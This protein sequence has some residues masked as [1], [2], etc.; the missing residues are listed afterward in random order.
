MSYLGFNQT[1]KVVALNFSTIYNWSVDLIKATIISARIFAINTNFL[2]YRSQISYF[3]HIKWTRIMAPNPLLSHRHD[4]II[5]VS[6]TFRAFLC[7]NFLSV[8]SFTHI[9]NQISTEKIANF[10]RFLLVCR[11]QFSRF[12]VEGVQKL[13]KKSKRLYLGNPRLFFLP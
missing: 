13:R 8:V 2:E 11:P 3:A 6:S 5:Y 4:F 12:S 7:N 1:E 9:W 10:V